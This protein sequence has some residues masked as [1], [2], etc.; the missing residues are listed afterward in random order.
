MPYNLSSKFDCEPQFTDYNERNDPTY[1][2]RVFDNEGEAIDNEGKIIQYVL[3]KSDDSFYIGIEN[4]S[5]KKLK[6]KLILGDSVVND[7]PYKGQTSCVFELD[8]KGRKV[9]DVIVDGVDPEFEFT[10][11]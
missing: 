4:T 5:T 2:H 6:L 1:N 11:A 8:I 10:Y 9:F 3:K 7:G